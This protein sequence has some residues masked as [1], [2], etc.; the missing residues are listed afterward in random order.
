M[1]NIA[2]CSASRLL[3]GIN[4]IW[5]DEI[6]ACR[7]TEDEANEKESALAAVCAREKAMEGIAVD[8]SSKD[9]GEVPSVEEATSADTRNLPEF[10]VGGPW[11]AGREKM[12]AM[13]HVEVRAVGDARANRQRSVAKFVVEKVKEMASQSET[14]VGSEK[15]SVAP[16]PWT[17]LVHGLDPLFYS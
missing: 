8:E 13:N 1:N 3:N 12:I 2:E 9:R 6:N 15:T 7:E 17:Q 16:A 4:H 5:S 11:K 14:T 10:C